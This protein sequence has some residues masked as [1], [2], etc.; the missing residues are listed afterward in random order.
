MY[1]PGLDQT[2]TVDDQAAPHMMASG[3]M[4]LEQ[5]HADQ[6]QQAQAE[7]DRQAEERR[8]SAEA[9]RAAAKA[10]KT[11]TAQEK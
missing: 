1:H 6:A 3:W 4:P 9:S 2:V 8:Q 7:A 11:T 10:G 5:W